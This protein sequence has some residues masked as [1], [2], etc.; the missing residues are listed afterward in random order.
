MRAPREEA[1]H[2]EG[3]KVIDALLNDEIVDRGKEGGLKP[4][5]FKGEVDAVHPEGVFVF[6]FGNIC[7]SQ[8]G[9]I[10]NDEAT[11]TFIF[12]FERGEGIHA[13]PSPRMQ[14]GRG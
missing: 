5:F 9:T 4:P 6:E 3:K 13:L 11:L 8:A 10:A 2:V 7:I 14:I 12:I 1:G